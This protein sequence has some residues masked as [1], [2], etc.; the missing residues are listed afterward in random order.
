MGELISKQ[1]KEIIQLHE[2]LQGLFKKSAL[3]I[4]EIGKRLSDVKQL[5]NHG[6]F[7][8]WIENN[9]PFNRIT[10]W[11][12]MKVYEC[13]HAKRKIQLEDL[14]INEACVMAGVRKLLPAPESKAIPIGGKPPEMDL[15]KF[16]TH[17]KPLSGLDLKTTRI[18]YHNTY[19]YVERRGNQPY[20]CN[21]M[22]LVQPPGLPTADWLELQ[23]NLCIAYEIY[24]HKVEQAE[25]NGLVQP[26]QVTDMK[27]IIKHGKAARI[28]SVID[29][30]PKKSAS[31]KRSK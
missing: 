1:E 4:F 15:P 9:L 25:K 17:G 23:K 2:E 14:S 22:L 29:V 5:L 16:A 6:D 27:H 7:I 31:R 12:F 8:P 18:A 30:Q 11:K 10:A 13:F 24:F 26:P 21:S 28:N 3:L 20:P 19:I